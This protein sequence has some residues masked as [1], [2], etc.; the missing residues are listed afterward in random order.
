M[1]SIVNIQIIIRKAL[2]ILYSAFKNIYTIQVA[3]PKYVKVA[4]VVLIHKKAARMILLLKTIDL[5][6][7]HV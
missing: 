1:T 5:F 3:L 7:L 4:N 2:Y 6:H